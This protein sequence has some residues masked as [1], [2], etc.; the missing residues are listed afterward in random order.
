MLYLCS[1]LEDMNF[2]EERS[3]REGSLA[4][5]YEKSSESKELMHSVRS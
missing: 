5:Y 4:L 3:R 1:W 2:S